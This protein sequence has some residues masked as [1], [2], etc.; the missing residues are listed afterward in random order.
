MVE[1]DITPLIIELVDMF[2]ERTSGSSYLSVI[3]GGHFEKLVPQ[4]GGAEGWYFE[5]AGGENE[6]NEKKLGKG[7]GDLLDVVVSFNSSVNLI[8]A[9][10]STGYRLGIQSLDLPEEVAKFYGAYP[11]DSNQGWPALGPGM[12]N[13]VKACKVALVSDSIADAEEKAPTIF[14]VTPPDPEA[15][16]TLFSRT[17]PMKK[18]QS[19]WTLLDWPKLNNEGEFRLMSSEKTRGIYPRRRAVYGAPALCNVGLTRYAEFIKYSLQCLGCLMPILVVEDVASNLGSGVLCYESDVSALDLSIPWSII[20]TLARLSVEAGALDLSDSWM[21]SETVRLRMRIPAGEGSALVTRAG[22][23][24]GMRT[25][26]V[27]DTQIGL[28]IQLKAL[29]HV[30]GIDY[31]GYLDVLAE[32]A[33]ALADE[34]VEVGR[35]AALD[36]VRA[37]VSWI[38]STR[39]GL[40]P[41]ETLRALTHEPTTPIGEWAVQQ[42]RDTFRELYD[43]VGF[44]ANQFGDDSLALGR[45]DILVG[46]A[47]LGS[48]EH[49]YESEELDLGPFHLEVIKGSG[50]LATIVG[51]GIGFCMRAVQNTIFPERPEA[52]TKEVAMVALWARMTRVKN[53]PWWADLEAVLSKHV[54]D[55][56][57]VDMTPEEAARLIEEEPA[58]ARIFEYSSGLESIATLIGGTE[59]PSNKAPVLVAA[60]AA[61]DIEATKILHEEEGS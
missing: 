54:K 12:S 49:T 13:L 25:T 8:A 19:T 50:Y 21:I 37:V 6:L 23:A 28:P 45:P 33:L 36:E 38:T 14:D 31:R 48:L 52:M 16:I 32:R 4:D 24:S 40:K 57:A 35:Q 34:A 43:R 10:L 53:H 9:A 59:I 3:E 11:L 61:L 22:L 2:E 41:S 60:L 46:G 58:A 51:R 17:G 15:H 29:H 20:D 30:C 7:A 42:G 1:E 27:Q 26:S 47:P 39:E 55:W 44:I 5:P 56:S 18:W